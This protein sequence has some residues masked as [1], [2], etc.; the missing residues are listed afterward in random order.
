MTIS[1]S[2][3]ELMISTQLIYD[4]LRRRQAPTK[5]VD[6]KASLLEYTDNSGSS[7]YIFSTC[8]D[9]S[10]ATGL[11]IARNKSR[12][13]TI[14][15]QLGIPTPSSKVCD[16]FEDAL[17]FL[18]THSIIVI[19]PLDNKGGIGV[20]TAIRT[21][22]ALKKAFSYAHTQGRYILAQEHLFG[23]D[24]RLLIIDNTFTSAV[25][26]LPAHVSGDGYSAVSKLITIENTNPFR[27]DTSLSSLMHIDSEA[28]ERYLGPHIHD[29]PLD[30]EQ[31]QVVGPANVSLGG[32]LHEAT[33]LVTEKMI[34]DAKK[35]TAKLGL[36][37]CGVDMIWNR[38][39][40]TYGLIE[41]NAVPG[42][43]IH[44]DKFSKTSSN[45]TEKY[46]EWLLT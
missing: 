37:I 44:D 35:I 9:K 40:D 45:A 32:S 20:T 5:I 1:F 38:E 13:A 31:V 29:I 12:T 41:V 22:T 24:V 17:E 36:G 43:D 34:Q 11:L 7:H 33:H 27:N 10:S 23:D 18:N 30:K 4:E 28:A 26:R 8:S 46:V 6:A 15:A 25:T 2:R 16:S 14:A 3:D 42:I 21:K 39:N 19:K